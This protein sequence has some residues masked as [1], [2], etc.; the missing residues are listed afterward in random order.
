MRNRSGD[1]SSAPAPSQVGLLPPSPALPGSACP[2]LQRATATATYAPRRRSHPLDRLR[3]I[4]RPRATHDGLHRGAGE[5]AD[6]V[7]RASPC[8]PRRAELRLNAIHQGDRSQQASDVCGLPL[9]R[10]LRDVV[11]RQPELIVETSSQALVLPSQEV[12]NRRLQCK[13]EC[14]FERVSIRLNVA[15]RYG[16]KFAHHKRP[17]P[18][19]ELRISLVRVLTAAS[20]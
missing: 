18:V 1:R 10:K 2:Q 9:R 16:L 8:A 5:V 7:R 14:A 15:P 19:V 20:S 13:L 12:I 4:S 3:G 6:D 11:R 17:C